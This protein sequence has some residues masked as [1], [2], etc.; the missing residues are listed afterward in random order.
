MSKPCE[1]HHR[2][3]GDIDQGPGRRQWPGV[4]VAAQKFFINAFVGFQVRT[5]NMNWD[6]VVSGINPPPDK[7]ALTVPFHIIHHNAVGRIAF[8]PSQ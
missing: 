1:T 3:H 5:S 4:G 2:V 6:I 8:N 7:T